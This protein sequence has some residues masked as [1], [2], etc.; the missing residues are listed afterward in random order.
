MPDV[1]FHVGFMKTGS[2]FLQKV[3]FPSLN[4][5]NSISGMSNRGFLRLCRYIRSINPLF[6]NSSVICNLRSMS[7]DTNCEKTIF[8]WEQMI[9]GYL[10]DYREF[11]TFRDII[12]QSFPDA[13]ILVCIRR[14]D[15]LAES[16]YK[17]SLHTYHFQSPKSF[18]NYDDGQ[19]RRFRPT[20]AA[21]INVESL[22]FLPYV[23]AY[24][25]TFGRDNV[26]VLP[27]E[28]MRKAPERFFSRLGTFLGVDAPVPTAPSMENR[29]YSV[30]SARIA[31]V[32]NR[33]GRSKHN[34]CGIVPIRAFQ[35]RLAH[36]QSRGATYRFMLLVNRMTDPRILLQNGLD[37]L[38][39]VKGP[40]FDDK[41]KEEIL[42]LH[43]EVNRSLDAELKLDLHD[44]G[45]Y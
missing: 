18:L 27:Y 22:S 4:K 5:V 17:Q 37:K 16:L 10:N 26:C 14:Q 30:L 40:I 42:R 3:Y 44:L 6:I 28:W 25:E 39:Y 9:G 13:R 33:L 2:T 19:F 41:L 1:V 20:S 7:R 24:Q 15:D 29:G 43:E 8:S 23:R 11:H 31:L 45:Y 38:I 34:D 12:K 21:N 35:Q 36:M 32:L